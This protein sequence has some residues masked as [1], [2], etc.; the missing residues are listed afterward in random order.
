MKE[1][2]QEGYSQVFSELSKAT[3]RRGVYFPVWRATQL[4]PLD[5]PGKIVLNMSQAA[6]RVFDLQS[7]VP[8]PLGLVEEQTSCGSRHIPGLSMD[9]LGC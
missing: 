1:G 9:F 7:T 2:P 3:E 5:P 8:C 6:G 4:L